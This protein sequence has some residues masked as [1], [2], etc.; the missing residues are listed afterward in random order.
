MKHGKL[1]AFRARLLEYPGMGTAIYFATSASRARYQ[2]YQTVREF[3]GAAGV[4]LT[5]IQ[6][7]RAPEYDHYPGTPPGVIIG[8]LTGEVT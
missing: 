2:A 6:I 7:R 1:R 3:W 8:Q 4:R 5:R